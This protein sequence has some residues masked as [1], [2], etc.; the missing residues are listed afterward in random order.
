[1]L[2]YTLDRAEGAR[3]W[4]CHVCYVG[5]WMMK[6]PSFD[7]RAASALS[8][9]SMSAIAPASDAA[10]SVLKQ[11]DTERNS[12]KQVSRIDKTKPSREPVSGSLG[13]LSPRQLALA[14]ALVRGGSISAVAREQKVGRVTIHRWRHLPSFR[15]SSSGCMTFSQCKPLRRRSNRRSRQSVR[16][17]QRTPDSIACSTTFLD[18]GSASPRI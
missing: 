10:R 8:R 17:I 13:E 9:A 6:S 12:L 5:R 11:N 1:M 15:Q 16:P 7:G 3:C 2:G 18:V 4:N 14:R